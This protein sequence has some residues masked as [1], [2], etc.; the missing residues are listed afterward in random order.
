M[1]SS[2]KEKVVAVHVAWR[3]WEGSEWE[4]VLKEQGMT[5]EQIAQ[6]TGLPDGMM[7]GQVVGKQ[8]TMDTRTHTHIVHTADGQ[9][10]V[11]WLIVSKPQ[12]KLCPYLSY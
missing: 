9:I 11:L 6:L 3:E 8:H 4:E 5:D 1:F 7:R 12:P 2:V 10:L